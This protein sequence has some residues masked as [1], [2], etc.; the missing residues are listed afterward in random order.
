MGA[1]DWSGLFK[2]H[3]VDQTQ[4]E[5][6]GGSANEMAEISRTPFSHHPQNVELDPSG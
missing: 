2:F 1:L 3:S 4:A 6:K 5:E